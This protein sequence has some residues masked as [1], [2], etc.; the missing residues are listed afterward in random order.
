MK[1]SPPALTAGE[2]LNRSK[3]LLPQSGIVLG[4]A[5]ALN[6]GHGIYPQRFLWT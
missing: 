5:Q 2:Y 1:T 4:Q 6:V 3:T